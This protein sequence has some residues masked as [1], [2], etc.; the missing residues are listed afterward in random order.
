MGLTVDQAVTV[1][2]DS[3]EIP[4]VLVRAF[5]IPSGNAAMYYPEANFLVPKIADSKSKT[6]AFKN[7]S[8]SIYP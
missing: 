4:G 3:G 5:D 7:V 8:V 2:S 6:P 1:R